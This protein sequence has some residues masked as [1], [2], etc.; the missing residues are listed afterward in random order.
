MSDPYGKNVFITGAS[1]G[2]GKAC[3]QLFAKNGYRVYAGA[4]TQGRKRVA[5]HNGGEIIPVTI[6]VTNEDSVKNA[7]ETMV[8]EV[9]IGIV[10]HCAGIGIAGSAEDTLDEAAHRQMEVNYFGVLRVNRHILPRMRSR[11]NGLIVM[12]GSVAGIFAVPFQSH[13]S[14]SKYAI[15]AYARALRMELKKYNIHVSIVEPGDTKTGFTKARRYEMP[16]DSPYLDDCYRSVS[17]M[18]EDEQNGRSRITVAKA[19]FGIAQ[20]LSP[21]VSKVVGF[22]YKLLVF[23]SRFLP[24]RLIVYVLGKMYI[25]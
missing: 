24:E 3:A 2:I 19:V 4:R 11:G 1:S 23:L 8:A 7:V 10:V 13:Y 17:K 9:D 20:R 18:E 6:D 15:E 14:S 12:I 22:D 5:F 25:K 21:P 16:S